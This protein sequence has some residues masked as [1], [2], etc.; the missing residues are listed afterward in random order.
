MNDIINGSFEFLGGL[1][2]IINIVR[3]YKDKTIKGVSWLPVA[4]FCTWGLWNLHYYSSLNQWFSFYGGILL[5]SVN[6]YWILLV[7][8]YKFKSK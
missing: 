1:F 4:F 3:L 2:Y 5:A 6:I 8:Y 7:F